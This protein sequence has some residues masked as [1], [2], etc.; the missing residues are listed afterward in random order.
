MQQQQQL[1]QNESEIIDTLHIYVHVYIS[2]CVYICIY[3][4]FGI[5][6]HTAWPRAQNPS[7]SVNGPWLVGRGTFVPAEYAQSAARQAG[8][9]TRTAHTAFL[10]TWISATALPV[11][12]ILLMRMRYLRGSK[13]QQPSSMMAFRGTHRLH[14][15]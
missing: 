1:L 11:S 5:D 13:T 15:T 14:Q 9:V 6:C 12:M 3:T 2:I 4:G 7:A 10:G 8:Q